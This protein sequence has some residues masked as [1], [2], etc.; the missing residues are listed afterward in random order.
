[1]KEL[2]IAGT[3]L[4]VLNSGMLNGNGGGLLGSLF[5]G[6]NWNNAAMGA[7]ANNVLD[8][9]FETKENAVLRERIAKLESEKYSDRVGIDVYREAIGLSNKNDD[10]IRNNYKEL[11]QEAA[12]N[13]V[14]QARMEEK[15]NCLEQSI[16]SKIDST[17]QMFGMQMAHTNAFF[18]N[19]IDNTNKFFNMEV[20]NINHNLGTQIANTNKVLGMEIANTN[21]RI[22]TAQAETLREIQ[23]LAVNT[24]ERVEGLRAEVHA[25]VAL[26]SER[27]C[28]G[29][30]K[31]QGGINLEAERRHS[32]VE[33][34]AERRHHGDSKLHDGI[35]LEAER[36]S[37]ADDKLRCYCDSTFVP[38]KLVM[39]L[40]SICPPAQQAT[41]P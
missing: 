36:R 34:E 3:A 14:R 33:L 31:L 37:C 1:M 2:V 19:E 41:N 6:N 35:V 29:D 7:A 28:C 9:K 22:H 4:G 12:A 16:N 15:I 13:M 21:E 10:R 5:G 18:K 23:N 25:A 26:E 39:P 30:E 17:N 11:A 24:K 27:R 40:S 32:S 38:G 20:A 8:M